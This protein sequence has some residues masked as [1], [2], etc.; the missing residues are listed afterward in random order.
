MPPKSMQAGLTFYGYRPF[1]Q[2]YKLLLLAK[3]RAEERETRRRG[4]AGRSTTPSAAAAATPPNQGGEFRRDLRGG[5]TPEGVTLTEEIRRKEV[6]WM[7]DNVTR[8][9]LRL[10]ENIAKVLRQTYVCAGD[11][12]N[13]SDDLALQKIRDL[14]EDIDP[15]IMKIRKQKKRSS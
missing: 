7:V 10:P 9:L 13:L 6:N 1:R 12:A 4:D 5:E 11:D 15:E 2:I 3:E 14:L 8:K